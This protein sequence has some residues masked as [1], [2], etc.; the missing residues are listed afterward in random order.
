MFGAVARTQT[1]GSKNYVL[2][3]LVDSIWRGKNEALKN[4]SCTVFA[5]P[6]FTILVQAGHEPNVL[7]A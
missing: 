5:Q 6:T 7:P 1:S 4:A 2:T 3:G